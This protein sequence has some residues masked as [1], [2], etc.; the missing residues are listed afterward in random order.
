MKKEYSFN[1]EGKRLLQ[2]V[3]KWMRSEELEL[4][5]HA[6]GGDIPKEFTTAK[7]AK[8]L[9]NFSSCWD[10]RSM[11]KQA[12]DLKTK[13]NA[14]W[15]VQ[16]TD[17]TEHQRNTVSSV[18]APLG[19]VGVS[20]PTEKNFDYVVALGGA[21]FSCLYRPKY[22]NVLIQEQKIHAKKI[23]LLSGMR[24]IIE[25]ERAATDTYAPMAN[26]EYDLINTGAEQVF[27]LQKNY[28]E[29][30]YHNENENLSW[31]VRRYDL[32]T[33][34]PVLSLSGPSSEPQ[35][36]RANSADTY[37]FFIEKC[38][39]QPNQKLLLVTSQIYVPYQQIEAIRM[40]QEIYVE[41]VGFPTEWSL[42]L[43]GML[44]PANYLQEIR[45]A[46]LMQRLTGAA[47]PM[48]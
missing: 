24:P 14:R 46:M 11:Q 15:Q 29:E 4:L 3:E 22:I 44:E 43:Q 36:R 1:V 40:F 42:G 12:N 8:W 13:E 10:Y 21:R 5:V 25:T 7:L 20:V 2:A 18:I 41:T 6:F 26:T 23:V 27:G 30:C 47:H 34:I 9:L 35:R 32:K 28:R 38:G 48:A 16:S 19:L 31:A 37:K 39:I 45:S 17:I 33:E